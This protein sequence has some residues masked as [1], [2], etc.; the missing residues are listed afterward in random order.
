MFRSSFPASRSRASVLILTQLPGKIGR[1]RA[2]DM[3]I[4]RK[5]RKKHGAKFF[6]D[7]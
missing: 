1:F 3:Q 5:I 7:K 4:F 6:L 2:P